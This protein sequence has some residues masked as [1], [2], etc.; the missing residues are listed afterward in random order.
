MLLDYAEQ[1][2]DTEMTTEFDT[3]E[4]YGFGVAEGENA[5]LLE[6]V[7]EA[8]AEAHDDGTYEKLFKKYFPTLDDAHHPRLTRSGQ[9]AAMAHEPAQACPGLAGHPVRRPRADPRRGRR[10][11]PTG[12]RSRSSSPTPTSSPGCSPR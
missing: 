5:D 4:Q 10:S 6:A 1:N 11:R 7:N 8:F 12:R 2:P 9:E 3:G